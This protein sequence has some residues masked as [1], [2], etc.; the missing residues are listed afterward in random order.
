MF[1]GINIL[2]TSQGSESEP[3]PKHIFAREYKLYCFTNQN[4]TENKT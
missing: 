2:D 4:L 1:L 3:G